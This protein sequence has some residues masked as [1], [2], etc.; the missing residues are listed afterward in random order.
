MFLI[1]VTLLT[2]HPGWSPLELP[3]EEVRER[4]VEMCV[5]AGFLWCG[6]GVIVL[7]IALLVSMAFTLHATPFA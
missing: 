5:S 7:L 3:G 6:H 1:L 4:Q 2:T